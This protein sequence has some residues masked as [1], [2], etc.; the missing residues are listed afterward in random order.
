MPK[1]KKPR[2][3][4]LFVQN[5]KGKE[6]PNPEL[7]VVRRNKLL[8]KIKK[9]D[10][11]VKRRAEKQAQK[12]ENL[13]LKIKAYELAWQIIN[14]ATESGALR[15]RS[16]MV[17]EA[18]WI[19]KKMSPAKGKNKIGRGAKFKRVF[20]PTPDNLRGLEV[21]KLRMRFAKRFVEDAQKLL[22]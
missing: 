17:E 18:W 12:R 2:Q 1:I 22:K 3:I 10:L 19:V 15:I 14:S 7:A 8:D 20:G 16:D 5:K 13:K 4:E 21:E 9:H 11:E 6:N